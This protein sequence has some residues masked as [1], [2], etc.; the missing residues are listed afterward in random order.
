[1]FSTSQQ[2]LRRA[3]VAALAVTSLALSGCSSW[4]TGNAEQESSNSE[5]ISELEN[6]SDKPDPRQLKGVSTVS[7]FDEVEPVA[8]NPEPA[9]PVELTDID[10]NAVKVEDV[11]RIVALDMYGTYTKTLRGLGLSENIVGRTNSSNEESLKD[12]PVVTQ[13]GH[14]INVEAVL[15]LRP[16]L[17]IVD[18]SIGPRGAID[19]LRESGIPTVVM[20][21]DR[22]LEK[23]EE[24]IKNLAGVVGLQEEGDKLA[25]RSLGEYEE[26]VQAIREIAPEKPLKMAFLYARGDGGVF[27][28]LGKED[29]TDDLI[30]GLGGTDVATEQGIG[31]PSPAN[32]E[33]LAKLNPEVFVMM[34]EG[35]ESTGNLQGLLARPGVANTTAGKN[36]RILALPDGDS[37][38][39][40]PQTGE[41]LLRAAQALY[42]KDGQSQ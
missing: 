9:L 25:Q 39:F 35:L 16:S 40:G 1:M 29:S 34:S 3:V 42:L 5:I 2:N 15:S 18:H 30:T 31:A 41:M 27:Y 21:P 13:G 8:E 22:S 28:V 32:A 7:A 20:S 4:D 6:S 37:L 17:I 14:D 38:A 23:M 24:G 11:S 10:G 33:A 12:L 26:A 36:Q 19:Q